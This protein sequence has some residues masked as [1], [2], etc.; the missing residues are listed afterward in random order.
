[1]LGWFGL[2]L[3]SLPSF[4]AEPIHVYDA[5]SEHNLKNGRELLQWTD[6]GPGHAYEGGKSVRIHIG[7]TSGID[8]T[9]EFWSRG[10]HFTASYRSDGADRHGAKPQRQPQQSSIGYG[11]VDGS[12]EIWFRADLDDEARSDWQVIFESGGYPDGFALL[13]RTNGID[14]AELR[15]LKSA[16]REQI[17]DLTLPLLNFERSEFIQAVIVL[18]GDSEADGDDLVRLT[19]RDALGVRASVESTQGDFDSIAGKN[20]TGVFN[21]AGERFFGRARSLGGNQVAETKLAGFF[22]EIALIRVY[23]AALDDAA[24]TAAWL[25]RIDRSDDDRDGMTNFAEKLHGF[26]PKDPADALEDADR[27]GVSNVRELEA[28]SDPHESDTD[29]DGLED[30][31]EAAIGASPLAR[32]SDGDGLRDGDEAG[33]TEHATSPVHPDT[34]RDGVTDAIERMVGSDPNDAARTAASPRIS[35]LMAANTVTL[36]DEDRDTSDWIEIVNATGE[37][38]DL[39]GYH[40]TDDPEDLAKW[41]FPAD[42]KLDPSK[43][44]LVFAS[45]KDRARTGLELHTNFVLGARGEYLALVAPDGA[46][47]VHEFAP[48]YPPQRPDL[49]LD[50][51]AHYRPVATPGAVNRGPALTGFVAD[52]KFSH[53]RGFYD[54]PFE[55][56]IVSGTPGATIAYTTDGTLPSLANGT[57]SASERVVLP[58]ARTTV[59]RAAAFK[60]GLVPTNVD[61]HS[62]LFARDVA[63]QS[64]DADDYEYPVWTNRRGARRADYGMDD[65]SIVG[66]LYSRSQVEDSLQ[67]LPTLSIVTDAAHL[68]GPRNGVYANS[69]RTGN[70]WERPVSVELFGFDHGRDA[71]IDAGLRVVGRASRNYNRLK[72]NLRIVFRR[73]Y[74]NSLLEFPLFADSD[75]TTFNSL[76]LRGGNSDSWV[77]PLP[78]IRGRATYLRDQWHRDAHIAMG[79]SSQKQG[80]VHLYL[81]GMYWGVYHLF[82]RI[83]DDYMEQHA[84]GNASDWDVRDHVDAFDGDDASWREAVAIAERPTGLDDPTNYAELQRYIDLV[85]LVDYVL[86]HFYSNSDDWDQNN[87][88]A[89]RSRVAPDTFRFFAW[90]QERTLRNTLAPPDVRGATAIDKDTHVD[91]DD[92]TGPTHLHQRLRANPEYRLLFADRVRRHCF[93]GGPLTPD[94]AKALWDARAA[95][96]RPAMIAEAARWGDLHGRVNTVA[97]WEA[98]LAREKSRWFDRRTPILIRL[99]QERGLYPTIAAPEFRVDGRPQHGGSIRAGAR[100][101][102]SAAAGTIYYTLDGSDPRAVGG[103]VRGAAFAGDLDVTEAITLKA[104]VFDAEQWSALSEARFSLL[105]SDSTTAR[106]D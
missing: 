91:T 6:I 100:I 11:L 24:I 33:A 71:Q 101:G 63:L 59:L 5:A 39:A 27:D 85:D 79:G 21:L 3:A 34:D 46:G 31:D 30:G 19:A 10:T 55:V 57:R 47:V 93:D 7:H 45:G 94:G 4:A 12:F 74:G 87:V 92:Q 54:A 1:V 29:G 99:L 20:D 78:T 22:G 75:V 73:R 32:D 38:V 90:D 61:T 84:G 81:N 40:L 102:I 69:R 17:A 82:E 72:H 89:A 8:G 36:R 16:G 42:T 26:D 35:E 96:I 97:D 86:L 52:T 80:H 23:A 98:N 28:G 58:I 95:E 2:S 68:F 51:N 25:E 50:A 88:R 64:D 56:E 105:P 104:R 60:Q 62:Y 66:V 67:S 106:R 15:L 18:D 49:A 70:I 48:S 43:F 103:A 44:L 65:E 13:L 37:P 77:F 41:T 76:Q 53:D 83:E 14:P 9:G